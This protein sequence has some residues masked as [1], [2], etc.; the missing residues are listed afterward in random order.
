M[1]LPMIGRDLWRAAK[2]AQKLAEAGAGDPV[3]AERLG[4]AK[5]RAA[6]VTK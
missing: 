2:E 5:I 1:Q 6:P 3:G 4:K